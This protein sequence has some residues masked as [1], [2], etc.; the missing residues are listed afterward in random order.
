MEQVFGVIAVVV[1][2]ALVFL[3]AFYAPYRISRRM[4]FEGGASVAIAA[5][6]IFGLPILLWWVLDWPRDREPT[7]DPAIFK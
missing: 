3:L 2:I 7:T 4:G 1:A 5:S 6:A